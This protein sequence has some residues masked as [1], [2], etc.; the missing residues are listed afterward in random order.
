MKVKEVINELLFGRLVPENLKEEFEGINALAHASI[1]IPS[2]LWDYSKDE[3]FSQAMVE[4]KD[5]RISIDGVE[6]QRRG[7]CNKVVPREELFPVP[8]S[9][10]DKPSYL[11]DEWGNVLD[12]EEEL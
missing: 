8:A 2:L 6:M 9:K 12:G 10:L 7:T 3:E 4:G 1:T 5:Y 11:T